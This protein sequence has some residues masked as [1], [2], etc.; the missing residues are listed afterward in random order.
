MGTEYCI[1]HHN[2]LQ[3]NI[4]TVSKQPIAM[5]FATSLHV[6]ENEC[7]TFNINIFNLAG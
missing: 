3:R 1:E 2:A 5:S 4:A 7:N 6:V